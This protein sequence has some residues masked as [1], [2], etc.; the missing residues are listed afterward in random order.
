[1]PYN[2]NISRVASEVRDALP[3]MVTD[4]K[5]SASPDEHTQI[6]LAG[7][8]THVALQGIDDDSL[9]ELQVHGSNTPKAGPRTF[10]NTMN[11]R[12]IREKNIDAPSAVQPW[13]PDQGPMAL[14]ASINPTAPDSSG[15]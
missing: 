15:T 2:F 8:A 10:Y 5:K 13:T 9:I 4:A 11:A 14:K 3:R 6:E 7:Q 1:M 12:P